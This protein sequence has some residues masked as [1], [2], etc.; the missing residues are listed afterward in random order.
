[1]KRNNFL[2]ILLVLSICFM[3]NSVSLADVGDFESYDSDW[4]SDY[5]SD[6]GSDW[7]SDYSYGGGG[8]YSSRTDLWVLLL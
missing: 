5:D 6:W 3:F 7:D 2:I 8:Y 4:S 1:M